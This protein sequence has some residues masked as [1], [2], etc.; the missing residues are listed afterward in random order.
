[1]FDEH[2]EFSDLFHRLRRASNGYRAPD[3]SD[4]SVVD[5]MRGLEELEHLVFRHH[6]VENHVLAARFR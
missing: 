5:V 1:M 2:R 6:H 4:T 3:P